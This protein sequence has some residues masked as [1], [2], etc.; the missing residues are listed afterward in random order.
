MLPVS[1]SFDI[2][3]RSCAGEVAEWSIAA[4]LKTVDLKGS[5]GS[6]PSL[7]ARKGLPGG[8]ALDV[9]SSGMMIRTLS[10]A[11]LAA[12]ATAHCAAT[13]AADVKA[14][15]SPRRAPVRILLDSDMYTDFDDMG[16]LAVLHA[17]ADLG[18]CEILAMASCT[19][20][21]G[22]VAAI[23][24]C[25]AHFGRAGIPVGSS[26]IASAVKG[27]PKAHMKFVE[28]QGR[29]PGMFRHANSD[30]APD[31][32][33][34]YRRA[35]AGAPDKGVVICSLGFLSNMRALLESPPDQVSPLNGRA[36]VAK[37]VSKWVA[38]ACFYPH[39]HEFNSDG[40]AES[41]RIALA[42]WPTP[43]VFVDFQYGRHLYTGR[44]LAESDV[45]GS[46]VKDVFR[47]SLLPREEVTPRTWDQLA[48]HPSWDEAA[49]LVAVRG[50]GFAVERGF[51]EIT[52]GKGSCVWRYDPSSPSC[53]IVERETRQTVAETIDSLM[54]AAE[55]SRAGRATKR[56]SAP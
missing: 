18:E 30:D 43:I 33:E 53:R 8:S 20:D 39:G 1:P 44:A 7:S 21:N 34:V 55:R 42:G 31:A 26:K 17:L 40:D 38:M 51:Y 5:G 25:N 24:I 11:A 2:L 54:L 47:S 36:L 37:K 6:N 56:Q 9:R 35:L 14:A 41:S 13:C 23:E 3:P 19:R 15:A 10:F 49:V 46:P 50:K 12:L 29:Y 28:L 45:E 22:S 27:A 16:A 52:D 48:G 4:V 32:V